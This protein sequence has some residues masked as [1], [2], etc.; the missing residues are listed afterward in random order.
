MLGQII[1][2]PWC[3]EGRALVYLTLGK[4]PGGSAGQ[5]LPTSFPSSLT[6]PTHFSDKRE[7]LHLPS[8]IVGRRMT[9]GEG[10]TCLFWCLCFLGFFFLF[11]CATC[12]PHDQDKCDVASP[13]PMG[14]VTRVR[15]QRALCRVYQWCME[16]SHLVFPAVLDVNL[17]VFSVLASWLWLCFWLLYFFSLLMLEDFKTK[18]IKCPA[19][20]T[21]NR[22]ATLHGS[23]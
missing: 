1:D 8:L 6:T 12:G 21:G 22:G 16:D 13:S 20:M 14:G 17:D 7:K 11:F 23:F 2:V 19:W 3:D 18:T 10:V 5:D 9:A 4:W 15:Q